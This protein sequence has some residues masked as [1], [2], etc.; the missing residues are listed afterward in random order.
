MNDLGDKT[1]FTF[2]PKEHFLAEIVTPSTPMMMYWEKKKEIC[3]HCKE[4]ITK[5]DH[6]LIKEVEFWIPY[7]MKAEECVLANIVILGKADNATLLLTKDKIKEA[8]A[9][10]KVF[11]KLSN[12]EEKHEHKFPDKH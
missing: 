10:T 11:I 3:P 9:Q 8:L 4:T 1:R 5:G 7:D 6:Y 2:T 12:T